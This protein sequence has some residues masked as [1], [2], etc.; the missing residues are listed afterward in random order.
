MA[1]A[2]PP[3]ART[4][5]ATARNREPIL[6]VLRRVLPREARV[7]EIASGAGEHAVFIA[8]A[9]PQVRWR[10]SDPDPDARASIAAW[11]A[12]AGLANLDPP[13]A[14]DAA[15][16]ATWPAAPVEAVVCINMIHIS[17]WAATEG[18]MAGAG[19]VL[20]GGG[21]L[22][23]RDQRLQAQRPGG[24]DAFEAGDAVVH[25]DQHVGAAVPDALGDG[26]R[27]AIAVD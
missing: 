17:P 3:S 19:R 9:I 24:R 18:L 23:V 15:D 16:P 22:V 21:Q 26:R 20:S 12:A 1:G 7:L 6:Q 11:R 27:E 4:S 14:L 10:P 5:P 2:P 25:R 8:Q 13:L